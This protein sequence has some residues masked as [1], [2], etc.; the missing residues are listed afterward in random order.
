MNT[1]GCIMKEE[2]GKWDI[3][4]QRYYILLY[5]NEYDSKVDFDAYYNHRATIKYDSK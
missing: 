2:D 1:V 3:V 4:E 5:L